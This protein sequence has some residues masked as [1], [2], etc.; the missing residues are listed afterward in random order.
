MAL[1]ISRVPSIFTARGQARP[2]DPRD[3]RQRVGIDQGDI[4]DRR[5]GG[6]DPLGHLPDDGRRV[7]LAA[8]TSCRASSRLC[9]NTVARCRAAGLK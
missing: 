5:A 6:K 1:S 3:R 9:H 7:A 8:A 2:G 4:I